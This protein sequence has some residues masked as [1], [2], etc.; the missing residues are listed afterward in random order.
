MPEQHPVSADGLVDELRERCAKKVDVRGI[1]PLTGGSSSLTFIVQTDDAPIV[2]KVAPPGL[3]PVR[4]RDVLRQARLLRRLANHD[5]VLVPR[6]HFEDAG[7]P[8]FFGMSLVPGECVEPILD[9]SRDPANFARVRARAFDA[10][11][12]LAALHQLDPDDLGLGDEPVV[13]LS[14]EIDRWTRA[15][16]TVPEEWQGNYLDAAAS[17]HAWMPEPL[18]PVVNHGDYRLGNTL[19]DGDRLTAVIDWEIWS[20]GDPRVDLSWFCYFLDEARH[21][22]ASS[23]EPTGMPTRDEVVAAYTERLGRE[24]PDL[25]WFDAL[26]RYKE[27]AATALILKRAAGADPSV[28]MSRMVKAFPT[29][30]EEAR[31]QQITWVPVS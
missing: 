29:L 4:N 15:F 8:P 9:A 26:T 16:A 20:I 5:R 10:I 23:I 6:V 31:T 17:L 11:D 3:P 7:D 25:Q 27:A 1:E 18:P 14:A 2:L 19:C 22:A 21:P 30:L 12:V 24:L 13:S 28:T